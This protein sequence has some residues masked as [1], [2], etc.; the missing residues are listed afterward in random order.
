MPVL[1]GT[2]VSSN[3]HAASE[4]RQRAGAKLVLD[5][6]IEGKKNSILSNET[7]ILA[8]LE[9]EFAVLLA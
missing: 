2:S 9:Q 3:I 6:C 5:A 7:R 8:I 4:G 1:F